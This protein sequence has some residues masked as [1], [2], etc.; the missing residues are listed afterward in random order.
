MN[1]HPFLF[2]PRAAGRLLAAGALTALLAA[3]ASV[4]LG[5]R[6][7]PPPVRMPGEQA[8]GSALQPAQ[9]AVSE[10]PLSQPVQPSSTEGQPLP[11]LGETGSELPQSGAQ[12]A[13]ITD[14]NAHILTFSTRLAGGSAVPPSRSQASG[15]IDAIYDTQS[16]LLRW[17]ASWHDLSSPIT[18]IAFHGPAQQGQTAP[19][20]MIWPGPFGPRY[21]GRA[22]LT[23]QQALDLQQGSWYINVTTQSWPGGEIRGQMHV[24][25]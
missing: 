9:P 22:T 19:M 16:R 21:E 23:P 8:S 14:P 3:C 17:K 2:M 5:Q 12:P 1:M 11:P 10:Q 20:T 18:G 4:D 6:Y 7:D 13:P 24:V 15:Q 25:R